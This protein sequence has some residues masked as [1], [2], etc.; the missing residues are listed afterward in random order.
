MKV[1]YI[2][3]PY[4]IYIKIRVP[5]Q[6]ILKIQAKDP[7]PISSIADILNMKQDNPYNNQALFLIMYQIYLGLEKNKSVSDLFFSFRVG[8]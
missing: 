8:R 7:T 1:Q 5:F 3:S 6:A 4:N 2:V